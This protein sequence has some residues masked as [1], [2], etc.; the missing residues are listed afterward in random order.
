MSVY[1]W[2]GGGWELLVSF[3]FL[4]TGF[5]SHWSKRWEKKL[6]KL[7]KKCND[8]LITKTRANNTEE[9]KITQKNEEK[10]LRS[11]KTRRIEINR[12]MQNELIYGR[13][14][15]LIKM[16][17]MMS[18]EK[19]KE[20][21]SQNKSQRSHRNPIE[22]L[23]IPTGV[24]VTNS[25]IAIG[26]N[27]S[28]PFFIFSAQIWEFHCGVKMGVLNVPPFSWD[29]LGQMSHTPQLVHNNQHKK[30]LRKSKQNYFISLQHNTH[31]HLLEGVEFSLNVTEVF[32][33]RLFSIHSNWL[34]LDRR[35]SLIIPFSLYTAAFVI[36]VT[37]S[38]SVYCSIFS[39]FL[40]QIFLF[41]KLL[42]LSYFSFSFPPSLRLLFSRH[43]ILLFAIPSH[44]LTQKSSFSCSMIYFF[45]L[46]ICDKNK[47]ETLEQDAPQK[48]KFCL[49]QA[50]RTPHLK[51]PPHDPEYLLLIPAILHCYIS[52]CFPIAYDVDNMKIMPCG[53]NSINTQRGEV[54]GIM[55]I[56]ILI[57]HESL[58]Q[59]KTNIIKLC[60]N[61]LIFFILASFMSLVFDPELNQFSSLISH[62]KFMCTTSSNMRPKIHVLIQCL[63]IFRALG[64]LI[65]KLTLQKK[66]S[67]LPTVDMQHAPAKLSSK[68]HLFECVDVLAQSLKVGVTTEASWEFLNV[69][70]RQLSKFILQCK[71]IVGPLH[72]FNSIWCW[73]LYSMKY[74]FL[75]SLLFLEAFGIFSATTP[76]TEL[77]QF[78]SLMS[79]VISC[80]S[81]ALDENGPLILIG[82]SYKI[83]LS[84][85]PES[86]SNFYNYMALI[87]LEV[88]CI[89]PD[90]YSP[91]NLNGS[92][93]LLSYTGHTT[94]KSHSTLQEKLYQ[95][96]AVDEI[97]KLP[98]QVILFKKFRVVS[99]FT[100]KPKSIIKSHLSSLQSIITLLTLLHLHS[101]LLLSCYLKNIISI[102]LLG[103]IFLNYL[104]SNSP[105]PLNFN[106][107]ISYS[108]D[109]S[110]FNFFEFASFRIF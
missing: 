23:W 25:A 29:S 98:C 14:L 75:N 31:F 93:L 50:V 88:M 42:S 8:D 82:E 34:G 49:I 24:S 58:N 43:Q 46:F 73:G 61:S 11:D 62:P 110:P 106:I 92:P 37:S 64:T 48:K 41:D 9:K 67:Q 15:R 105:L 74:N 68:L 27:G 7:K 96:P 44:F 40:V 33:L 51:P 71:C 90:R 19:R 99:T 87:T 36:F 107:S 22:M 20:E 85:R 35:Q 103:E 59:I 16:C 26:Q 21:K 95:M 65:Q 80:F 56:L 57:K 100:L 77:N 69:N 55:I 10:N 86:L 60:C 102:F 63:K 17:D 4:H 104:L 53:T 45:L 6:W 101:Y 72:F 3:V 28:L 38:S 76:A 52:K 2:G 97:Q 1:F 39:T 89:S 109:F 32:F 47:K 81:K 12:M 108:F 54:N 83:L 18:G 66:L 30:N 91:H 84:I 78:S 70:C 79:P 5:G 94:S 13:R